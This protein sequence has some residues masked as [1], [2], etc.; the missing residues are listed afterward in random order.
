MLAYD[1]SRTSEVY[2]GTIPLIVLATILV[3]IRLIARNISVAKLW[4]DDYV[5]VVALVSN[6]RTLCSV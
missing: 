1:Q 4:W 5:I 2:G 6:D 3:I